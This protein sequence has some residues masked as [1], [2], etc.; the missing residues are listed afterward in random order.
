MKKFLL[1]AVVASL[2][3]SSCIQRDKRYS[4]VVPIS[5]PTITFTGPQLFSIPTGGS[6]PA[7]SA[8]AYDSLI[9]ESYTVSL[10][11]TDALDNT[12]PGL[13][14]IQ[15]QATNRYGFVSQE[16]VYV[17]VTDIPTEADLS[18]QYLRTGTSAI[19]DVTEEANG[20]YSSDNL[21]GSTSLFVT[22]FFVQVDDTT[23]IIPDQ[24]TEIGDLEVSDIFLRTNPG[25]TAYGYKIRTLTSNAALREFVKQ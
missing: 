16:N 8:T 6:L 13:Y 7:V 18:G 17:A 25:D 9:G 19:A 20:L 22:F 12:T 5:Y 4:L 15:A 24:P 23:L 1:A 14:I 3:L 11:G 10:A 2:A 21:F